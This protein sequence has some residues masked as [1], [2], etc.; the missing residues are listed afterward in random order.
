MFTENYLLMCRNCL[1]IQTLKAQT[2]PDQNSPLELNDGDAYSVIMRNGE[3][4]AF[5]WSSNEDL[6]YASMEPIWL[7]KLDQLARLITTWNQKYSTAFFKNIASNSQYRAVPPEGYES[8][9]EQLLQ[10]F[11]FEE[12]GKIWN[13]ETKVWDLKE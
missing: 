8:I 6:P 10:F 9:E 13:E 4:K 2:D 3:D 12:H 11:M 5:F 1:E 7:P